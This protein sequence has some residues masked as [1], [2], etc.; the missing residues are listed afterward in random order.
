MD[1]TNPVKRL[2]RLLYALISTSHSAGRPAA[3]AWMTV[4]GA[5]DRVEFMRAMPDIV[6]LLE[7]CEYAIM[8]DDRL[9]TDRYLAL[10]NDIKVPLLE[11][12]FFGTVSELRA[13]VS[14]DKLM[15]LEFAADALQMSEVIPED[16][17]IQTLIAQVSEL[18]VEIMESELDADLKIYLFNGAKAIHAALLHYGTFGNH[19]LKLA[20]FSQ[21]GMI[22]VLQDD[23]NKSSIGEKCL[24][25]AHTVRTVLSSSELRIGLKMLAAA[26][27]SSSLLALEPGDVEIV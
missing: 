23:P 25:V 10:V 27:P 9:D 1:Q 14:T 13:A 3:D 7:S 12:G 22:S 8:Q 21:I 6:D 2:H 15:V 24:A 19:G 26:D 17:Q 4:L 16:E 11:R 18:M 5:S 20:F